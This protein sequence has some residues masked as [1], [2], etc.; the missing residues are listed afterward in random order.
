[1]NHRKALSAEREVGLPSIA[2]DAQLQRIALEAGSVPIVIAPN[3]S[4]GQAREMIEHRFFTHIAAVNEEFSLVFLQQS[5]G[6][7]HHFGAIVGVAEDAYEHMGEDSR[8]GG[9]LTLRL[10][11]A[12]FGRWIVG[13]RLKPYVRWF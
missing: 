4:R 3:E 9:D 6:S 13:R 1:M 5:D 12:I 7:S 8:I 11:G 2:T 10:T